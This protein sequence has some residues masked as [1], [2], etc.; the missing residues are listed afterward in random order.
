MADGE[1]TE[2]EDA[3]RE[4]F[5]ALYCYCGPSR[6]GDIKESLEELAASRKATVEVAEIDLCRGGPA[7][8]LAD[9]KIVDALIFV[10]NTGKYQVGILSPPCNTFSRVLFANKFGPRQL[11]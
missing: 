5:H 8:N 7:H 2:P 11:R 4:M 10:I 3:D 9:N 6:R 1:T